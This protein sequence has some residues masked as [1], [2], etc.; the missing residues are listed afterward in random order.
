MITLTPITG[1]PGAVDLA[2]IDRNF[3]TIVNYLNRTLSVADGGT[4]N[5][6][7]TDGQLLI[8]NSAST[9]L[10]KTTITAGSN[11]TVTNGNGSITLAAT[12]PAQQMTLL[13][14]NSGPSTN[15]SANDLDTF[16][17]T[18]LTS[19]DSLLIYFT[20][21]ALT[22]SGGQITIQSATDSFNICQINGGGVCTSGHT[23]MGTIV[24]KQSQE[25]TTTYNSVTTDSLTI[26]NGGNIAGNVNGNSAG[27][28]TAWT[29]P[30][31]ISLHNTGVTSG[32]TLRWSWDLYKV[33]GQ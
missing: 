31:T 6:T 32:G 20:V 22:Q 33:L 15:T 16:A 19:K 24:I 5:I 14:A 8:G 17:I 7:Y 9:G 4:G 1:S 23:I 28:T 26:T 21:S 27:V 12:A 10:T 3:T 2:T 30:W 13:K 11:M 25:S 29:S 18:G